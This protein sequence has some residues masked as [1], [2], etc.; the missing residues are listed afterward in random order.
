[1]LSELGVSTADQDG[2]K[3]NGKVAKAL[4]KKF[5]SGPK[6]RE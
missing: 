2:Y 4:N 1:M 3:S 6:A 5:V